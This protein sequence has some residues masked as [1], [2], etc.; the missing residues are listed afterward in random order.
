MTDL[1]KHFLVVTSPRSEHGVSWGPFPLA[2]AQEFARQ[3]TNRL[4]I[5]AKDEHEP[6]PRIYN[7]TRAEPA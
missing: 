7:Y 2:E 1:P 6:N 3:Q 4:V 5:D